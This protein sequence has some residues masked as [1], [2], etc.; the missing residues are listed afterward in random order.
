MAGYR[1]SRQAGITRR[2]ARF[3]RS[4]NALHDRLRST[5]DPATRVQ[6]C[7]DY[8]LAAIR[9]A[10]HRGYPLDRGPGRKVLDAVLRAL[11]T[12]GDQLLRPA[13]RKEG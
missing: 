4:K 11:T 12:A 2:E 3:R 10:Q 7:T 13:H 8:V 6:L 9:H 1:R 5:A